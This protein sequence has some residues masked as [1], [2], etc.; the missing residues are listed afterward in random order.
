M[1]RLAVVLICG[2]L[3]GCRGPKG[4][5]GAQGQNGTNGIGVD[6]VAKVYEYNGTF[7]SSGG[8]TVTPGLKLETYYIYNVYYAPSGSDIYIGLSNT[9]TAGARSYG[10]DFGNNRVHFYNMS[11]GDK[12]KLVVGVT[13]KSAPMPSGQFGDRLL[14]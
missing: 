13:S 8:W 12:Y 7:D 11:A 2:V 6:G 5:T 4:A 3:L 10:I 1:R 9:Q 14:W